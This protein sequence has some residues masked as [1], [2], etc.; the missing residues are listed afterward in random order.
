MRVSELMLSH[1]KRGPGRGSCITGQS[2]HNQRIERLW[3]D[4]LMDC[5]SLFYHLFYTLEDSGWLDD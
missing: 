4:L 5:T 3:R 1:P 2:V